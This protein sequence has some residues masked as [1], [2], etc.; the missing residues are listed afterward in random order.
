M[1]KMTIEQLEAKGWIA[2]KCVSGSRAYGLETPQ[3]D[4]D[5]KGVFILPKKEYYG[6]NY[7]DQIANASND[8]VF[9]ELK[10]YVELLAKNNPNL[11]EL[12]ATPKDS[13]LAKHPIMGILTP[14][15]FLSKQCFQSFGKYAMAQIKKAR[16][17]NKKIL[18]P[19]DKKRKG[20]LDFCYVVQKEGALPVKEFLR[21]KGLLQEDCGLTNVPHMHDIYCM[22]YE[23]L[24][25]F[26]GIVSGV[27]ANDIS[28][29]SI[30]KGL[31]PVAIMSFNKTGYSKYCK[32]YKAYWDWVGDRNE[33]RYENTVSHKKNYD[34]KN[35]MH[36][37][38]L[39]NMAEEIANEHQINVRRTDRDFLLEIK[40]GVFEYEE[41]LNRATAKMRRV[42]AAFAK[43]K[44]PETP[45][46]EE[47]EKILVEIRT[48]AYL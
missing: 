11:L 17:L 28:L 22:Y 2:Q 33:V 31:D 23:K 42:E 38:R 44:L 16:G 27:E 19:V 20:V 10:R 1:D 37:F 29:S 41:L 13:V 5:I 46:F 15:L 4:T 24:S 32:E 21:G 39:L 14:E 8:I 45:D 9:Y 43:S 26:K 36:T 18:N 35:M 12:L 40:N 25:S 6:L 30:P 48:E 7:V 47:I 34:A 3:S